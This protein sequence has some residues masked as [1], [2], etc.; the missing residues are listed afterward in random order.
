MI[1]DYQQTVQSMFIL[2]I[3][4]HKDKQT[5]N[6]SQTKWMKQKLSKYSPSDNKSMKNKTTKIFS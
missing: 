5:L 1:K 2:K 6:I 4:I 3:N